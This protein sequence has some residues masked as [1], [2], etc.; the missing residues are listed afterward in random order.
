MAPIIEIWAD[1]N[2]KTE[3][4]RIRL[5]TKGS[6]NAIK[7]YWRTTNPVGNKVFLCDGEIGC[8][9]I[10]EDDGDGHLLGRPI[11]PYMDISD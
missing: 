3:D 11:T 4:D 5:T 7:D 9:A 2:A 6:Q 10:I 1:F 8:V